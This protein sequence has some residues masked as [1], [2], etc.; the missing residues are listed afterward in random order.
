MKHTISTD[1]HLIL[2]STDKHSILG[3]GS[4]SCLANVFQ[5]GCHHLFKSITLSLP[6]IPIDKMGDKDFVGALMT[7]P[8]VLAILTEPY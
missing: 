8:L 7:G 2:V 6:F 4:N 5:Y 3:T 1:K